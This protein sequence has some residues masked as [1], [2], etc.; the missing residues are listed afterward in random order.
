MGDFMITEDFIAKLEAEIGK[1]QTELADLRKQLAKAQRLRSRDW[2]VA[3]CLLVTCRG[4]SP[5]RG[6]ARDAQ[7]CC[8]PSP[9]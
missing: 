7:P 8:S 2:A 3:R 6:C 9:A 4:G 5:R 1:V